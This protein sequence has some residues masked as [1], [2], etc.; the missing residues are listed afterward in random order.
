MISYPE[1]D[2]KTKKEGKEKKRN[3]LTR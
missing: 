2:K 1:K 3:P